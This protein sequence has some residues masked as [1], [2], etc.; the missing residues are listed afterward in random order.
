MKKYNILA[1]YNKA[2]NDLGKLN[3][4]IS[5]L[6]REKDYKVS[7]IEKDFEQ[8]ITIA[9]NEKEQLE[10]MITCVKSIIKK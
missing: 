1:E 7:K 6:Q 8:Q 9:L 10:A 4:K 3:D 5:N 2:V